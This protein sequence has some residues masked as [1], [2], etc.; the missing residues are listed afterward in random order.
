[1]SETE[2]GDCLAEYKET[3]TTST[4]V[5]TCYPSNPDRNGYIPDLRHR[6]VLER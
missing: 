1:M 2:D 5:L 6:R 4:I 3:R